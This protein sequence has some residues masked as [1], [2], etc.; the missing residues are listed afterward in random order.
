MRLP[1]QAG[2]RANPWPSVAVRLS[3]VVSRFVCTPWY[4]RDA[5]LGASQAS[6][7]GIYVMNATSCRLN[8]I[9]LAAFATAAAPGCK[10]QEKCD[11]ALET[12]RK[13][14][15]EEYLDMGAAREW[16]EHAGKI[17]GAGAELEALDKEIV[18]KEAEL[19]KTAEENAKT[20]AANGQRALAA[21][22]KLW[23]KFDR[24]DEKA[25]DSKALTSYFAKAKKLT[26]QGLS[27]EYKQQVDSYNSKQ[28][29][30]RKKK[31]SE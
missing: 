7:E 17:C 5:P 14:M 28:Y 29:K 15:Q 2:S 3:A 22:V 23:K 8:W 11:E 1:F 18:A 25:R 30:A 20:E 19:I 10:D 24:L 27:D 21:A 4:T 26:A 12:A 6:L 9:L 31:L 13:S 16:R